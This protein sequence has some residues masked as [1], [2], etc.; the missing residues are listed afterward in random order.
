LPK[1]LRTGPAVRHEKIRV[2][3]LSADFHKHATAYLVAELFELH[4]RS[5]FEIMGVAFDW[6]DGSDMRRRLVKSFDHFH[7]VRARSNHEVA[8]LLHQHEVDIA[9]DLKGHTGDSR[10][11]IFA[12]RPTP[13]QAS[14]L[15]YPG[16][17]GAEFMDYVIGDPVVTPMDHEAF[18]LEK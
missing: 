12:H 8:R 16:T 6:D 13:I 7:D 14:Y 4:D 2:A 10:L 17:L 5:R 1:P 9:V 18:Y 15:G 11:G 3:Y